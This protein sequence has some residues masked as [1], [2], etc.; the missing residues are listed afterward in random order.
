ME[1]VG[2]GLYRG[3]TWEIYRKDNKCSVIIYPI[4]PIEEEY[5]K[6]QT[7]FRYKR[8]ECREIARIMICHLWQLYD[9]YEIGLNN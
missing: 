8:K 4:Y 5:M 9:K 7:T 1:K 3:V 2:E 6:C